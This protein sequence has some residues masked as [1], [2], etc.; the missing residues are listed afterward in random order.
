MAAEK[1]FNPSAADIPT[2]CNDASLPANE[3]LR[4][5]TPLIDPAVDG[6]DVANALSAQTVASPLDA[7][8][9]SIADLL[10]ENG[11]DAFTGAA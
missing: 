7:T 5:I 9:K 10:S 4:G 11:F 3:L 6:A 1:N 8:G 2:I